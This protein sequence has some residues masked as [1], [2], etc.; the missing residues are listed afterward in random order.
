MVLGTKIR[1]VLHLPGLHI[2]VKQPDACVSCGK[3]NRE[4]PMGIIVSELIKDGQIKNAECIQCGAC[5]DGCPKKVL[6][7]GM[8]ERGKKNGNRKEK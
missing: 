6:S 8:M 3:C 4:C 2:K 1:R 7:Y 5:I